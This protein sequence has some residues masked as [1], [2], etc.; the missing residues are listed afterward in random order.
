MDYV[1]IALLIFGGLIGL[2]AVAGFIILFTVAAI[3]HTRQDIND[4]D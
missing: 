3:I 4:G 2:A 1:F